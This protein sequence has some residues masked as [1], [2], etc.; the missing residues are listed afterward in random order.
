MTKFALTWRYASAL[1][2]LAVLSGGAHLVMTHILGEEKQRAKLIDLSLRQRSLSQRVVVLGYVADRGLEADARARSLAE[3]HTA[4]LDLLAVRAHVVEAQTGRLAPGDDA[5]WREIDQRMDAFVNTARAVA[6]YA[7]SGE[8]IPG[9][10]LERL[11]EAGGLR[12]LTGL[13]TLILRQ[14]QKTEESLVRLG[15]LQMG[16]AIGSLTVLALMG[17]TLFRP[18]VNDIVADRQELEA[19]NREL[20]RLAT[21][22]CLTGL[23]NRRK[24]DEVIAREMELVRRYADRVALIMFDIDHFK[25]INDTYGHAVGDRV[26]AELARLALGEVRAVDY[27]FRWGGEEFL[28]LAPRTGE[29]EAFVMAEK[30]RTAVGGHAF[31]DGVRL[32]VS[33]GV[34]EYRSGEPLEDW[35]T[36]VDQALYAAKRGGRNKTMAG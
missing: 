21:A 30:L 4:I 19:A 28:I 13:D 29:H 12:L 16:F 36:R 18:L 20:S 1:L 25:T 26:L 35:L 22:D 2:L 7:R 11:S 23:F 33:L 10:Q 15:R 27:V 14:Q 5:V 8:D 9:A 3:M 31:P 17:V 24:F 34:A 32:T 6:E